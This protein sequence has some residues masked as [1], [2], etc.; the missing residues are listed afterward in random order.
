MQVGGFLQ[1]V[2]GCFDYTHGPRG[3]GGLKGK[4][5]RGGGRVPR[6]TRCAEIRNQLGVKKEK[7]GNSNKENIS[8]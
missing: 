7:T 1:H 6:G 4:P 8:L 5:G 2:V 3:G